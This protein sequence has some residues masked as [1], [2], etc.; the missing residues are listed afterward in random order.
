MEFAVEESLDDILRSAKLC[1]QTNLFAGE[2]GTFVDVAPRSAPLVAPPWPGKT[3][4]P[5]VAFL[6]FADELDPESCLATAEPNLLSF[7]AVDDFCGD[8]E[9]EEDADDFLPLFL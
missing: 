8:G 5:D 2:E 7:E 4:A 3:A 6:S 1:W 9:E